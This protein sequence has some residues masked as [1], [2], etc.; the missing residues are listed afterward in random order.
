MYFKV[1]LVFFLFDIRPQGQD[2]KNEAPGVAGQA[3]QAGQDGT[4]G[5]AGPAGAA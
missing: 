1:S 3:G 2:G 5:G 4:G